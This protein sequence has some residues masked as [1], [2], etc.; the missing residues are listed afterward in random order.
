MRFCQLRHTPKIRFIGLQSSC[1]GGRHAMAA[2]QSLCSGSARAVFA[3]SDEGICRLWGGSGLCHIGRDGRRSEAFHK[4]VPP[5]CGRA[6][7]RPHLLFLFYLGRDQVKPLADRVGAQPPSRRRRR[8]TASRDP[9]A[10]CPAP[11]QSTAAKSST[12]RCF[13]RKS[14]AKC[15]SRVPPPCPFPTDPTAA[16]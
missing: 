14:A 11:S 7:G 5:R 12:A 2:R 10:A 8:A 6:A 13:C 9:L 3:A 1:T 4:P 15:F 16:R